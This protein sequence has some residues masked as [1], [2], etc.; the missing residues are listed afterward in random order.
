MCIEER[1]EK[2]LQAVNEKIG[3]TRD[4]GRDGKGYLDQHQQEP[5]TGEIELGDR[6]CGRNTEGRIDRH[7]DQRRQHRQHDGVAGIGMGDGGRIG[8]PALR[9]RLD[10]D[11]DKRRQD[12]N[13]ADDQHKRNQA[14]ANERRVADAWRFAM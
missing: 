7:G 13:G 1:A 4:D 11:D 3:D 6:P 8:L 5:S 12:Q 10:A 9:K 2:P 14:A